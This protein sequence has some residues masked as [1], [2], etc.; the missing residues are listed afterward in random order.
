MDYFRG[1]APGTNDNSSPLAALT[2]T[3]AEFQFDV[4]RQPGRFD[5]WQQY[6]ISTDLISWSPAANVTTNSITA[7][8]DGS[9]T[10]HL[11]VPRPP[12]EPAFF[13]RLVIGLN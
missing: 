6:E 8:T 4:R 9:E 5:V 3:V 10:V 2:L 1:T 11:S 12:G 7:E 13:L